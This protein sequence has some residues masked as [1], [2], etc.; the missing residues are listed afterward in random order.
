MMFRNL[1]VLPALLAI[2]VQAAVP[3]DFLIARQSSPEDCLKPC[4]A[5]TNTLTNSSTSTQ[6]C[7]DDVVR[8]YATCFSCG[9]KTGGE[10]QQD[11]QD[12]FNTF[13]DECKQA[14]HPITNITFNSDGSTTGLKSGA[15]RLSAGIAAGAA[16][17]FAVSFLAF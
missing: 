7:T 9:V 3:R 10:T 2:S 6:V 5:L 15:G 11:A 4:D 12:T 16:T 17:V 1:I 13:A 8:S 14:G